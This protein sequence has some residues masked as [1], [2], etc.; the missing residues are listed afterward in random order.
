MQIKKIFEAD[1]KQ[2]QKRAKIIKSQMD[3]PIQK[4]IKI[5]KE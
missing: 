2:S 4:L 3:D 5:I 1:D